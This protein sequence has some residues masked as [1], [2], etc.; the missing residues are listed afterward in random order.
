MP[1]RGLG[2]TLV[3]AHSTTGRARV[4]CAQPRPRL[5]ASMS[6]VKV[7]ALAGLP[8]LRLVSATL[9]QDSTGA[10]TPVARIVLS[11][12]RPTVAVNDSVRLDA[13][14]LDAAG[15]PL[16]DAKIVFKSVGPAQA[17]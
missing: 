14:A 11:T 8:L 17:Q 10:A 13:R 7:L 5:E 4:S 16:T 9:A 6:V 2:A 12:P 15:R 3:E 1:G